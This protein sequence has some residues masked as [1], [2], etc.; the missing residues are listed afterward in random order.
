MLY[1]QIIGVEFRESAVLIFAVLDL[2]LAVDGDA[3]AEAL[4]VEDAGEGELE[5][6]L[7][8]GNGEDGVLH[9]PPALVRATYPMRS[10]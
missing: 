5:L 3:A 4:E 1:Y 2:D 6:V 9:A 8:P 7:L 10:S